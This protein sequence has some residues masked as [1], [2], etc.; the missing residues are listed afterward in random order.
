LKTYHLAGNTLISHTAKI[1]GAGAEASVWG[2]MNSSPFCFNHSFLGKACLT[3]WKL[4]SHRK[5]RLMKAVGKQTSI[6]GTT[7]SITVHCRAME[8]GVGEAGPLF[9]SPHQ[10]QEVDSQSLSPQAGAWCRIIHATQLGRYSCCKI[11]WDGDITYLLLYIESRV[12]DPLGHNCS[13]QFTT[14]LF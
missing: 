6:C 13:F 7:Q 1:A 9:F 10:G 3:L 5:A 4:P 12:K 2:G 11:P 8:H 14:T